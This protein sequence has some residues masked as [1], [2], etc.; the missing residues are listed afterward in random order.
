MLGDPWRNLRYG[1]RTLVKNPG[2]TAMAVLT[3]ARCIGATTSMFSVVYATLFEPM[4]Y[5]KPDQLMMVWTRYLGE[6]GA[7]SVGDYS[8]MNFAVAQRTH[9]FGVR[10]AL[11]ARGANILSMVLREGG[12]LAFIGLVFGLGGAYLVGRAMQST[13][14]GVSAMDIGSFGTAALTLLASALIACYLPAR[15]A[16][17]VDPMVALQC[18]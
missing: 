1:A 16:S 3:L 11:G 17:K 14:Y 13:L 10:M 18:D 8:E 9:E 12:T 2:F 5:T 6:R 7:S 4:P 15:R